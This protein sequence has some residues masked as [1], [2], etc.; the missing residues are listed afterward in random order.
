MARIAGID[1]PKQKKAFI[2]LTYIFGIGPKVSMDILT[3]ANV[4]PEKKI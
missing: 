3:K 4:N 2:G 1:L